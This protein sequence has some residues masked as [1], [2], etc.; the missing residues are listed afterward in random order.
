M[1]KDRINSSPEPS[2]E[3]GGREYIF[4]PGRDAGL[5]AALVGDK[6]INLLNARSVGCT[7]PEFVVIKSTA[8]GLQKDK[9][10]HIVREAV[11]GLEKLTGKKLGSVDHPLIFSIRE[12]CSR[13]I[14]GYL[15]TSLCIGMTIEQIPALKKEIGE[16]AAIHTYIKALEELLRA[17][18]PEKENDIQQYISFLKRN[19]PVYEYFDNEQTREYIRL[20]ELQTSEIDPLLLSDPMRQVLYVVEH[21]YND[22]R[23]REE[24]L[25][26]SIKEEYP[27]PALIFQRMAWSIAGWYGLLNTRDPDTGQGI[28]LTF[29]E[30]IFGDEIMTGGMKPQ[31]MSFDTPEE[32]SG[33]FSGLSRF[34]T[35]YKS[36]L[37]KLYHDALTLEVVFDGCVLH[38]LQ[39]N[40][41]EK[42]PEAAFIIVFDLI[43]EGLL[44]ETDIMN[45]IRPMHVK[46]L[47]APLSY[48]ASSA[49]KLLGSGIS[50]LPRTMVTGKVYFTNESFLRALEA[51]ETE[52][53]ILKEFFDTVRDKDILLKASGIAAL[54]NAVVHVRQIALR[55]VT[56]FLYDLQKGGLMFRDGKLTNGI[57]TI[58]E[59][60]WVSISSKEH[61]LY[62]G[63]AVQQRSMFSLLME[64]AEVA[65]RSEKEENLYRKLAENYRMYLELMARIGKER[66]STFDDAYRYITLAGKDGLE[67]VKAEVDSWAARNIDVL[68]EA[69]L[70]VDYGD[71]S[72]I[73]EVFTMLSVEHR[74]EFYSRIA[75]KRIENVGFGTLGALLPELDLVF[76]QQFTDRPDDILYLIK[77]KLYHYAY[78]DIKS[79]H[80]DRGR[81]LRSFLRN[82][83]VSIDRL[84]ITVTFV[85]SDKQLMPLKYCGVDLNMLSQK[86]SGKVK[87]FIDILKGLKHS[88]FS[89]WDAGR[90]EKALGIRMDAD[91][92][93]DKT[94]GWTMHQPI[95][96]NDQIKQYLFT[97]RESGIMDPNLI[98]DKGVNLYTAQKFGCSVPEFVILTSALHGAG[99]DE[100]EQAISEALQVLGSMT[101]LGYGDMNRPLIISVRSVCAKYIPGYLDT[102][103]CIGV[104]R[105]M[106]P[107]LCSRYSEGSALRIYIKNL[108]ALF[109]ILSPESSLLSDSRAGKHDY[110]QYL[111]REI[112]KTDSSV[113]DS[114]KRQ[115]AAVLNHLYA[116]FDSKADVLAVT[117]SEKVPRMAVILQR[118]VFS[119]NGSY[120]VLNTRNPESGE[121]MHLF[122]HESIFGDDIMTGNIIPHELFFHRHDEIKAEHPEVAGFL[123][124]FKAPLEQSYK[125][126]LTVEYVIE[127]GKFYVLQI[128]HLNKSAQAAVIIAFDLLNEGI[129]TRDEVFKF[130]TPQ[131]LKRLESSSFYGKEKADLAAMGRGVS[132]LPR[133]LTSGKAYFSNEAV[134]SAYKQGERELIL[135][136]EGFDP[137]ADLAAQECCSGL[138]ALGNAVVH[139]RQW[140]W[141]NNIACLFD[142]ER[143]GLKFNQGE[144]HCPGNIIVREGDWVTISSKNA[145]LYLGRAVQK[146]NSLMSL[147]AGEAVDFESDDDRRYL[148]KL[149]ACYREY[150]S[151]L[152]EI[153]VEHIDDLSSLRDYIRK[154][155][156]E[157][158]QIKVRNI[159]NRWIRGHLQGFVQDVLH[160]GFGD[161]IN[162]KPIFQAMEQDVLYLFY[163]EA[164][165][166]RL[167]N[168]GFSILGFYLP[169]YD[170]SFWEGF[171][172]DPEAVAYLVG[173]R[174]YYLAYF[175]LRAYYGDRGRQIESALEKTGVKQEDVDITKELVLNDEH[176]MTLR[177]SDVDLDIVL[178]K[179]SGQVANVISLLRD[180]RPQDLSEWQRGRL[181]RNL[182][183]TLDTMWIYD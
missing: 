57:E 31:S 53:I 35:Q 127:N 120:G 125:D 95:I 136:K 93:Q 146:R 32:M 72:K 142:L 21:L 91:V 177:F 54:G 169:S 82:E 59:G 7:V 48:K 18:N 140:A 88:D 147:Y 139:T 89:D 167:P 149:L 128:N 11:S 175:D 171:R 114:P 96:E 47:S 94:A 1:D 103:L 52:V 152:G 75:A 55:E 84:D 15:P 110:V 155:E 68:V 137:A 3:T 77:E 124:Q 121:G 90:I 92:L 56:P 26:I 27:R 109:R 164:V 38:V 20:L 118:M 81:A 156:R 158:N 111:E 174:L 80:G 87:D 69:F 17:S 170:R 176:F 130:I 73:R 25:S 99:N 144:L 181:E 49:Q 4:I 29:R 159:A 116:D 141:A 138:C 102:A 143:V 36:G 33:T 67:K 44:P 58:E 151:L 160:L 112:A 154:H 131:Y 165:K 37:E 13:Y 163:T 66:F 173:E 62:R 100:R 172:E 104:T 183:I 65:F 2:G 126:G 148:N 115:L 117:T 39:V 166:L 123:A 41:L 50:V 63:K 61:S 60:E 98:G 30:R 8:Y 161:H 106:L 179:S 19:H 145:T 83:G 129:L 22:F 34:I 113:L 79:E 180:I 6:T 14:P 107:A 43:R 122:C 28:H 182:G 76:W 5:D 86:A 168:P 40:T 132:I 12:I 85:K 64:Q 46:R 178:S 105:G 42:S 162:V 78:E 74:N 157:Q 24:S 71:H 9:L 51:G 108:E 134:L 10:E 135:I 97:G 133:L 23:L 150:K 153:D 70:N 119:I 101:G 16:Q 45:I